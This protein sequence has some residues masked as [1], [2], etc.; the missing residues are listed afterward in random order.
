M[1]TQNVLF[2]AMSR[3]TTAMKSLKICEITFASHN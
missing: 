2:N 1:W 3:L